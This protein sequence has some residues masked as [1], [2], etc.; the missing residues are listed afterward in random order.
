MYIFMIELKIAL[1]GTLAAALP[2]IHKEGIFF[3]EA[4]PCFTTDLSLAYCKYAQKGYNPPRF[5][6]GETMIE[7][8]ELLNRGLIPRQDSPE[9]LL[10]AAR[11]YWNT[12]DNSGAVFF[13]DV[14]KW[15]PGPGPTAVLRF[16]P[17]TREVRGGITR[18]LYNHVALYKRAADVSHE[19]ITRRRE[20]MQK[21]G[22]WHPESQ[23]GEEETKKAAANKRSKQCRHHIP[24]KDIVMWLPV[25][26]E[27]R[28]MLAQYNRCAIGFENHDNLAANIKEAFLHDIISM[29][30]VDEEFKKEFLP[31]FI[32]DEMRYNAVSSELK[33]C[34]LSILRNSGY[35]IIKADYLEPYEENDHVFRLAEEI[36]AYL[37]ALSGIIQQDG[38]FNRTFGASFTLIKDLWKPGKGLDNPAVIY[39]TFQDHRP[40][41]VRCSALLNSG[42][43]NG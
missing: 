21:E 29:H 42:G 27:F 16:D 15:V 5:Y 38:F 4:D 22:A 33:R 23:R 31:V 8:K 32:L 9:Q 1:H 6:T 34:F 26:P 19:A 35:K 7:A 14:S 17:A 41:C 24:L 2:G 3:T 25:R 40:S 43:K 20:R 18:W 12:Y 11:E 36:D 39:D 13:I 30:E 28:K 37:S 10:E